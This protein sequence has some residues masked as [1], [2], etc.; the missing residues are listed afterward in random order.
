[1]P[2][3]VQTHGPGLSERRDGL[4]EM[5]VIADKR[6]IRAAAGEDPA[7]RTEVTAHTVAQ[8]L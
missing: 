5:E 2:G 4:G 7:I 1:M 3:D 6:S 8:D